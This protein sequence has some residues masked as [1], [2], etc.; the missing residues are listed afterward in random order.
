MKNRLPIDVQRWQFPRGAARSVAHASGV[1]ASA[2]SRSRTLSNRYFSRAD[3]DKSLFRRDAETSTPEARATQTNREERAIPV[4]PL[5][6]RWQVNRSDHTARTPAAKLNRREFKRHE[7]R[8][9]AQSFVLVFGQRS[10]GATGK[11]QQLLSTS[12]M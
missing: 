9:T 2:S 1:L 3:V 7:A 6:P 11:H 10:T 4:G 8:V 5:Q 12:I